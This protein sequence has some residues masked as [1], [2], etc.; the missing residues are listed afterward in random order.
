MDVKILGMGCPKCKRLTELV[1]E[2]NQVPHRPTQ[3]VQPPDYQGVALPELV[4]AVV[5]AGPSRF[6]PA[7]LVQED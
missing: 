2:V 6:G 1:H 7:H 3:P 5:Q 4:Q